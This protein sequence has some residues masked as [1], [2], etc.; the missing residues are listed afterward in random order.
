MPCLK[1][2]T[3]L[4]QS[5]VGVDV[6]DGPDCLSHNGVSNG[7]ACVALAHGLCHYGVHVVT[8][9]LVGYTQVPQDAQQLDL[10]SPH[11]LIF[12]AEDEDWLSALASAETMDV[13]CHECS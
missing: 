4:Q 13:A 8:S 11:H 6:G 5:W 3:R 7:V 2:L 10:R 1:S 9:L 12:A